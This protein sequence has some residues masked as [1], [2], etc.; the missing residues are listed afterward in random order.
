MRRALIAVICTL[1]A[2]ACRVAAGGVP[3]TQPVDDVTF[4]HDVAPIVFS[5]CAA[6]HRPGESAPF[7]L[8]SYDDV[9]RRARQI[10]D[11]TQKRFMPPWLPNEGDF[12][13]DRRLSDRE[14]ET[15]K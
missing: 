6:C 4:A 7:G 14:L 15:I 2:G 12:I 8:L 10:V 9:R 13:G 11:V 5:H 1:L 3:S